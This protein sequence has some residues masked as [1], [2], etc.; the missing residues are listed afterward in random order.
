MTHRP[1]VA[2][3]PHYP[4][5]THVTKQSELTSFI[6]R[7]V[8]R[9]VVVG[10]LRFP[11]RMDYV[12]CLVEHGLVQDE[13][14]LWQKDEIIVAIQNHWHQSGQSGCVFSRYLTRDA[15][16]SGWK[17][18]VFHL[19]PAGEHD[20]GR[21]G[22]N[23]ILDEEIASK[24]CELLSLLFPAAT[25]GSDLANVLGVLAGLN[26]SVVLRPK[27]HGH[28]VDFSIRIHLAK[29]IQAWV[30]GFGPFSFLPI[31]R[32]APVVEVVF[33]TKTQTQRTTERGGD[34]LAVHVADVPVNVKARQFNGLWSAS[35]RQTGDILGSGD[36]VFSRARVTFGLP[37]E[38]FAS[39]TGT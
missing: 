24:E 26:R 7:F 28:L 37:R 2:A 31:T 6:N 30:L 15:V 20:S 11:S 16:V 8:R 13:F 32:Q 3:C 4:I 27:P 34:L 12:E 1:V 14:D 38:S 36:R 5:R 39:I 9:S 19:H 23:A 29:G 22:L 10:R 33:R 18:R 17:A 35:V 21:A 25:T